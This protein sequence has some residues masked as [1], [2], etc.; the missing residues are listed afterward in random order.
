M[1]RRKFPPRPHADASQGELFVMDDLM[2]MKQR[3]ANI[4]HTLDEAYRR[5]VLQGAVIRE[6]IDEL[7]TIRDELTD[8]QQPS[9]FED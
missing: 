2:V 9:L 4:R 3:L 8:S 7:E 1:R 6:V 5:A